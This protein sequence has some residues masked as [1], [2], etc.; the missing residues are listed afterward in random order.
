MTE[1]ISNETE[2]KPER[3]DLQRAFAHLR[4]SYQQKG[5]LTLK[6]RKKLLKSLKKAVI[7]RKAEFVEAIGTDFRGR[8]SHE[9][10]GAEVFTLVTSI[11]HTLYHLDDWVEACEKE[12][13][14]VFWPAYI[15]VRPQPLGVVGILSPW[16]YPMS[17]ALIPLASNPLD[18]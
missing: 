2:K 18:Q 8:S 7:R 17:L 15:E 16:N 10:I 9:T 11:K 6:E 13:S 14:W 3:N 12:V 4:E 1:P 5:S